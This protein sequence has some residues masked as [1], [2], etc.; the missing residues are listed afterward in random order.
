MPIGILAYIWLCDWQQWDL[1]LSVINFCLSFVPWVANDLSMASLRPQFFA[2]KSPPLSPIIFLG[3]NPDKVQNR[4]IT[5]TWRK[6]TR[7]ERREK[8]LLIVDTST[9]CL[10]RPRAAHVHSSDKYFC[11]PTH[12]TTQPS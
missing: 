2:T 3:W 8:T 5:P 6:V 4:T 9:F 1:A 12:L 11:H 10:Q 7:A